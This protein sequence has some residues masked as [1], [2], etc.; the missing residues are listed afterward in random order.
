MANRKFGWHS[1]IVHAKKII[2]TGSATD[3]LHPSMQ[4]GFYGAANALKDTALVDN[5]FASINVRTATNKTVADCSTMALYVGNGN[6]ADT[7]HNKMQGI[8]S[9]MNIGFDVFDAYAGQFHISISD[10][11]ATHAG[12]ANLVGLACKANIADSKT[13]TGNV[14]ALYVVLDSG[15]G[16]TA[17]GSYDMIRLENNAA[18]CISAIAFGDTTNMDFLM[19]MGTGGCVA[20]ASTTTLGANGYAIKVKINGETCYIRAPTSWS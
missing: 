18:N 8:L 2:T 16:T 15:T 5:I 9:S 4:V 19:S 17:T 13:A 20:S 12:N 14:S 10:T 1:G 6:T 3:Y 7:I 11:M